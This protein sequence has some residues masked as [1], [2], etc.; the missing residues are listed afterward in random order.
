[1][2]HQLVDLT[3]NH[4]PWCPSSF[5]LFYFSPQGFQF[6]S[7]PQSSPTLCYCMD[8][9]ANQASL[10]T[11][12]SWSLLK[13]MSI[14]SVIPPNHLILC[15]LLSSLLQSFPASES[16]LV[17]QF[18]SSGGQGIGVSASASILPMN[19]QDWFPLGWTGWISLLSKGLSRI[20][21]NTIVQ[22]HQFFGT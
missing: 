10:F 17:S 21:S 20:F 12:N 18:F 16:F 2:S 22:K 19:I 14:E 15:H 9:A 7:V 6:G 11:T 4:N 13:L 5:L 8:F 1:M 3:S